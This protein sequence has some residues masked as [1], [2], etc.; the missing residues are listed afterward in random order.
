M[1]LITIQSFVYSIPG[2]ICG[3]CVALILNMGLRCVVYSYADNAL[4]YYL[5]MGAL[6]LGISYGLIMPLLAV[7]L[8]I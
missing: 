5:P 2:I 3:L 8:P 7:L 4:G 1:A 6:T